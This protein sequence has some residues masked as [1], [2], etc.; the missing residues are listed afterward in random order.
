MVFGRMVNTYRIS[1]NENLQTIVGYYRWIILIDGLCRRG[2]ASYGGSLSEKTRLLLGTSSAY[3]YDG[4]ATHPGT[5]D[6][7]AHGW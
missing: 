4:G 5:S 6:S 2:T 7:T 3:H 1:W